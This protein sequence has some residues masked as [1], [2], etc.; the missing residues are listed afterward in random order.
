MSRKY[1]WFLFLFMVLSMHHSALLSQNMMVQDLRNE[2]LV[3][4]QNKNALVPL[5]ENIFDQKSINLYLDLNKYQDYHLLVD[6]P[7]KT[8]LLFENKIV[9]SSK[10]RSVKHFG[11]DS[12]KRIYP[13]DSILIS[14]FS[15]DLKLGEI[16]SEIID[17]DSNQLRSSADSIMDISKRVQNDYN[18]FFIMAI[19]IVLGSVVLVKQSLKTTFFDYI[20]V[21][22]TFSIKPKSE[23]LY[24]TGV[25]ASSNI[26][27]FFLYGI[28]LG[29]I[30]VMALVSLRGKVIIDLE[31]E[32]PLELVGVSLLVS[33][34]LIFLMV[35]RY[36]LLRLVGGIF[37]MKALVSIQFF[38]Y[39]RITFFI[40]LVLF[41]ALIFNFGTGG[42]LI[43]I[44]EISLT[45]FFILTLCLRPLLIYFK[46]NKLSGNKNLQLFSYICGTELIP[47]IIITNIFLN[48]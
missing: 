10:K 19:F 48:I 7:T 4:D 22:S 15:T 18:D 11:I 45:I 8:S 13:R 30:V 1:N 29:F 35:M 34:V 23:A 6:L 25:F 9:F 37:K 31:I 32:K 5:V 20:S 40:L 38:D 46:L 42:S 28:S 21:S 39:F 16:S 17:K 3:Y 47:L 33:L 14:I 24:S 36:F 12:L 43:H 26:L 41:F 44:N 2:W 27:M